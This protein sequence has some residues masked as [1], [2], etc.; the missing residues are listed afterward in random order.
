MV[1]HAA[2]LGVPAYFEAV[3]CSCLLWC[4]SSDLLT[5]SAHVANAGLGLYGFITFI[6]DGPAAFLIGALDMRVAPAFDRPWLATSL[7]DFWGR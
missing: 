4:A 2:D 5:L 6:M 3:T 7:A 1:L